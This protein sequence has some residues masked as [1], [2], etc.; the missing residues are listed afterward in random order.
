VTVQISMSVSI[1]LLLS[2]RMELLDVVMRKLLRNVVSVD[3][4]SAAFVEVCLKHQ[5]P[6]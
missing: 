4:F 6:R 1:L 5:L 2:C 3:V